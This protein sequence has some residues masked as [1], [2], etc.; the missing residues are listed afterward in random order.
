MFPIDYPNKYLIQIFNCSPVSFELLVQIFLNLKLAQVR[1][2]PPNPCG[3]GGGCSL[4]KI[5]LSELR[6]FNFQLLVQLKLNALVITFQLNFLILRK[7]MFL[8]LFIWCLPFSPT[9][10]TPTGIASTFTFSKLQNIL[11]TDG[12]M[13]LKFLQ[14]IGT[15][16]INIH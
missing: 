1:N 8:V 11:R 16:P 7:F 3:R 14:V 9:F 10:F 12:L 5:G 6:F 4:P 13:G 15:V 2:I